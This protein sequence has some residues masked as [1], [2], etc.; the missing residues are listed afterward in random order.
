MLPSTCFVAFFVII[1]KCFSGL[2]L[3]AESSGSHAAD[4]GAHCLGMALFILA[5]PHCT[6]SARGQKALA[7]L[8][9]SKYSLDFAQGAGGMLP[10]LGLPVVFLSSI[11]SSGRDA[12]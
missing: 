11:I 8:V 12:E 2:A 6:G 4:Y 7:L 1:W 10:R 3:R 9:I 5:A